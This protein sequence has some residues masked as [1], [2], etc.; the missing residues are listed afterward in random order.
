LVGGALVGTRSESK[1]PV[2]TPAE[3]P[4]PAELRAPVTPPAAEAA[5]LEAEESPAQG[6]AESPPSNL[7]ADEPR[8]TA[9][10]RPKDH[11]AQEVALLSRATSALR[12]GRAADALKTLNEH[13]RQFP[14]GM[15]AQERRGARAQALCA[16]GRRQ[17]AQADLATLARTAPQSPQAARARQA[18]EAAR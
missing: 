15:L 7:E 12:A 1:A 9:P 11:L 3:R 18:C 5:I 8:A 2:A 10:R 13:Q 6:E 14:R 4:E 16:L 17:E